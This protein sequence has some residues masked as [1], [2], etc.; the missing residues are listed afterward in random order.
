MERIAQPGAMDVVPLPL[1]VMRSVATAVAKIFPVLLA[2]NM[3]FLLFVWLC[4]ERDVGNAPTFRAWK[5]RAH[6]SI[7]IP[8]MCGWGRTELNR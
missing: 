4:L 3:V 5:A 6:L 1:L 8:R 7:P 2:L